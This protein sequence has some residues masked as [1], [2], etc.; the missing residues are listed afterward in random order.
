LVA[1]TNNGKFAY[2]S[3]TGS[4]SVTGF[5]VDNASLDILDA[6]GRTGATGTTPI[7]AAMS[8]NAQFLYV[9]TAGSRAVS[10]FAVRQ[11]DGSL[12]PVAGAG[13]LPAGSVGLAAW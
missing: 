12:S 10:A 3:N 1:V 6:D 5:A 11:S 13:G 2:A 8:R 4:A 7:D 9:L